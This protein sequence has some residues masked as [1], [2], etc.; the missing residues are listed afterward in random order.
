[1][2]AGAS[3]SLDLMDK[4]AFFTPAEGGVKFMVKTHSPEGG[5]VSPVHPPDILKRVLL[6]PVIAVSVIIRSDVPT[7]EMV[8]VFARLPIV[9]K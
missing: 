6:T 3:G 8:I 7:F 5:N 1:M 4:V 9:K 2:T